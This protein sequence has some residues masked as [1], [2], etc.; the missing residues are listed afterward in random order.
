VCVCV[1][2]WMGGGQ[3]G[4]RARG[5]ERGATRE[6]HRLPLP[7]SLSSALLTR[8]TSIVYLGAISVRHCRAKGVMGAWATTMARY[9]AS[10]RM[11][12]AYSLT[13]FTP[14]FGSVGK[15]TKAWSV[16][17][18]C[19]GA[20]MVRSSRLGASPKRSRNASSVVLRS[21]WGRVS[22]GGVVRG[23][24]GRVRV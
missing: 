10:A 1:G 18:S 23:W 7:L 21:S 5:A 8:T 22:G 17:S 13:P 3:A 9:T 24:R 12:S 20:R 19:L 11:R 2:G 4:G 6:A 14:T 15:N 16:G